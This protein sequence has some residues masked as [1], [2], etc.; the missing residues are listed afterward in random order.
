MRR[1]GMIKTVVTR[2]IY[3]FATRVLTW[4]GL[5]YGFPAAK[6]A[7]IHILRHAIA[8]L[9]RKITAPRIR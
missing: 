4:P 7:G 8:V 3:P 1:P 2:M 6:N 9:R 5:L